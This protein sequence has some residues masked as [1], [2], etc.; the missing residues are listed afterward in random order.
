MLLGED[1]KFFN[2]DD[3]RLRMTVDSPSQPRLQN[4]LLATQ[5]KSIIL[6]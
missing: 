5:E 4:R 3:G 6:L 2:V 1:G